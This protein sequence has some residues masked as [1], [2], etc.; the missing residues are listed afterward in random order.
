MAPF[1]VKAP[2][3]VVGVAGGRAEL[4]CRVGGEPPPNLTW[5]RVDGRLPVGRV[6]VVKG[7]GLVVNPLRPEDAGVYLCKASNKAAHITAN[8]SLIVLSKS[9]ITN[10]GLISCS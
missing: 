2:R 3:D 4:S 9:L 10:P 6:R 8:A 7:R 1:W 5:R